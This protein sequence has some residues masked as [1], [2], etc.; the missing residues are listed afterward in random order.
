MAS[1]RNCRG[2]PSGHLA[3]LALL[4]VLFDVQAQSNEHFGSEWQ[5]E[6]VG[7]HL[8][9]PSLSSFSMDATYHEAAD[10]VVDRRKLESQLIRDGKLQLRR[11]RYWG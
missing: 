5:P 9:L 4:L 10:R 3:L 7:D 2:P 1:R 8:A 11:R 6:H